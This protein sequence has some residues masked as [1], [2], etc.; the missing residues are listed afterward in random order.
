MS[1]IVVRAFALI[2]LCLPLARGADLFH[3]DFSRFPVGHLTY[4]VDSVGG[5]IQE[6]HY[7]RNRGVPLGPWENSIS[8][9][10]AWLIGEDDGTPYLEQSVAVQTRDPRNVENNTN[11]I[12]LTGDPEWSDCTVQVRIQPLATS[13]F[14]GLV[15][16]YQTSHHY[17]LFALTGGNKALLSVRQA[18]DKGFFE[19][20][21]HRL[22]ITDFPY[23]V[24]LGYYTLKVENDGPR[25]RAYVDSK[26]VL[27]AEDSELLKGKTG[28]TSNTPTRF[29]DFRVTV[30]D[31]VLA[32]IRDR[33]HRREAELEELRAGNPK[34]KLWKKFS[35]G[36]FGAG[37]AVA[38]G[39]LDGDGKP[40]LLIAQNVENEISCLTAV[41]LDGK[42]LWQVGK[43][44]PRNALLDSPVP[45][46]VHD[47]YGDGHDDVV[48]IKD[49]KLEVLDGRTGKLLHAVP[50]PLW[51]GYTGTNHGP[52]Y[53]DFP[54][55][56]R[57][58][59]DSLAF[60]NVSGDKCRHEIFIKDEYWNFW[61]YNNK[62]ELLWHGQGQLG[63]Y[64]YPFDVDGR[65]EIAIGYSLWDPDG[66]QL[67]SRD[68]DLFDHADA[69][70]VGNYGPD[71]E[72]SSRMY[73][74]GSDEGFIVIDSRGNI[75]KHVRIGHAQRLCVGKFRTEMPGLQL[76]TVTFWGNP[77]IVTLFDTDGNILEQEEPTHGGNVLLPVNWRG[78]GQEFI[79]INGDP[80][81]GG[82]MDGQLRRVV[83][84]PDDG[85]PV[86]TAYVA[87]LTGDARDEIVLLNTKEVW[88]Y[89]QDRPFVGKRIYA[90]V[91]NLDYN[92]S[93]YRGEVSLPRWQDLK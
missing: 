9:S 76:A 54:V 20:A 12:F 55:V 53:E 84:F 23:D 60:V 67:W 10:D 89:T 71:P 3:D 38:F 32:A 83:M 79:L 59:G 58:K 1:Q 82:M 39:D 70:I 48:L 17:Y 24:A 65:D 75:L 36:N 66:K 93:D 80:K 77:G 42:V 63:H 86:L 31:S 13:G 8:H 61:I 25:I 7:L 14:A 57:T 49:F 2:V 69:V 47:I 11:P 50:T 52:T 18:L 5:S 81:E 6:Y 78:D 68:R 37:R 88:I 91:R 34:P 90:P 45:F 56:G 33:I 15:F 85:H 19:P 73:A 64:P 62:L 44:D 40:D 16:R 46:E 28:V 29:Q 22:A 35:L 30:S 92:E 51:P 21:W 43:P 41:T 74:V 87:N 27:Q 72:A 26:L 4:P